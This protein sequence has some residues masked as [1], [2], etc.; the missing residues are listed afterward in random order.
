MSKSIQ[1]IFFIKVVFINLLVL[2]SEIVMR[3]SVP[4]EQYWTFYLIPTIAILVSLISFLVTNSKSSKKNISFML[5]TLFAIK[6]FS[7]VILTV[8]FFIL[9]KGKVTRLFIMTIIFTTYLLNTY[10][11]LKSVLAYHKRKD[12]FNRKVVKYTAEEKKL[13]S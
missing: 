10:V 3:K 12:F 2:I 1:K 5:T 6:F 8:V 13:G 11:L 9:E 4:T 7:Y